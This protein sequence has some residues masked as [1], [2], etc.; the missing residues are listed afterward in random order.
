MEKRSIVNGSDSFQ[1]KNYKYAKV[2]FA[3]FKEASSKKHD[4]EKARAEDDRGRLG[5]PPGQRLSGFAAVAIGLAS[6]RGQIA[7]G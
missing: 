4:Q 1:V 5:W 7:S 2:Q 3:W 6:I